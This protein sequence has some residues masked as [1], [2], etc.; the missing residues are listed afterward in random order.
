M[1]KRRTTRRKTT[2]RRTTKTKRK[3]TAKRKTTSWFKSSTAKK[4]T[5]HTHSHKSMKGSNYSAGKSKHGSWAKKSGGRPCTICHLQHSAS[6]HKHH[7]P[8]SFRS[9]RGTRPS[10]QYKA[11]QKTTTTVKYKR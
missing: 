1:V 2:T 7:G 9:N 11:Y 4:G 6:A 10:P 5:R 3:T 8:Q